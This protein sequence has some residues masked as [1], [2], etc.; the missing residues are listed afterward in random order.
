MQIIKCEYIQR[1]EIGMAFQKRD[2]LM[3]GEYKFDIIALNINHYFPEGY[4]IFP[5]YKRVNIDSLS[6]GEIN[7]NKYIVLKIV[8]KLYKVK[9][10]LLLGED[11]KKNILKVSI[12]N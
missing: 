11:D 12:Y 1:H 9:A 5:F 8:S 3:N 7:Y 4:N 6:L 2:I 10:I